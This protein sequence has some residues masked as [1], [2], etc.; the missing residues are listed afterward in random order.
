M[1]RYHGVPVRIVSDRDPKFTSEFWQSLAQHLGTELKMSTSSHP[2]TDGQSESAVR[3]LKESLRSYLCYDQDDWETLLPSIEFALNSTP[4]A[5][6]GYTPFELDT[7]YLPSGPLAATLKQD[8]LSPA[9]DPLKTSLTTYVPLLLKL[10]VAQDVQ[11]ARQELKSKP[12]AF[13]VGDK[14]YVHRNRLKDLTQSQRPSRKLRQL[15]CGPFVI[16]DC[17]GDNAVQLDLPKEFTLPS[18]SSSSSDMSTALPALS[19][20]KSR[21]RLLL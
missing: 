12:S 15:Y 10:A 8:N 19:L 5:S 6:T 1:F 13:N 2:Q 9:V 16:T 17:I 4:S 20:D 11:S 14:V 18:T 21:P 3:Q 7:G